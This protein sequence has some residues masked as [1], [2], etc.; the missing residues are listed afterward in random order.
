MQKE[1]S[2]SL[3]MLLHKAL[4]LHV[5][6]VASFAPVTSAV[7][8]RKAHHGVALGDLNLEDLI[9]F[10]MSSQAGE[11]LPPTASQTHQ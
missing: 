3:T 1:E 8:A 6:G 7:E 5:D 11:A 9:L 10:H 2:Y 4:Q